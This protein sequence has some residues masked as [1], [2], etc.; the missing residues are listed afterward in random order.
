M[1]RGTIRPII[2]VGPRNTVHMKDTG[3]AKDKR[4]AGIRRVYAFDYSKAL[5]NRFANSV[6][7]DLVVLLDPDVAAVFRDGESVNGVLRALI[8][9]MPPVPGAGLR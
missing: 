5:P 2:A 8:R 3:K 1:K 6:R 4:S 9:C 7:R